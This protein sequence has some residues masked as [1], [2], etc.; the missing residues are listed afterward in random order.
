MKYLIS[1]LQK[2][3][4]FIDFKAS[5]ESAKIDVLSELHRN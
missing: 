4:V 1:E 2:H 3:K 5:Y